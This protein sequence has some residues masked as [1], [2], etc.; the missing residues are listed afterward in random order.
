MKL[1]AARAAEI[2]GCSLYFKKKCDYILPDSITKGS[3]AAVSSHK[4]E[5]TNKI[6]AFSKCAKHAVKAGCNNL[7]TPSNMTT[8]PTKKDINPTPGNLDELTALKHFHGKSQSEAANL[9]FECPTYYE[10]DLK[11]MGSKA[12][13]FYFPSMEPY[14]LSEAS[15]DD[16]D[17]INALANTLQIRLKQD[18]QSIKG[19]LVPALRILDYISEN[20]QKFNVDPTIYGNITVKLSNIINQIRLL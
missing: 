17:I 20:M 13:A 8:I 1:L 12:F 19:C 7:T 5:L 10:E 3:A 4:N 9:F 15:E 6:K 2:T 14:L 18:P 16:S 11:W